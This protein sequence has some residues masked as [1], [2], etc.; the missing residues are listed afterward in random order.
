MPESIRLGA[1]AGSKEGPRCTQQSTPRRGSASVKLRKKQEGSNREGSEG[2]FK[3]ERG[4]Y[5]ARGG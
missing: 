2:G 4:L 5:A 3:I 1:L